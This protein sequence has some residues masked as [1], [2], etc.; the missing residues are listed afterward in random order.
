MCDTPFLCETLAPQDQGAILTIALEDIHADRKGRSHLFLSSICI[1]NT[2][3]RE[4]FI[5]KNIS[6]VAYDDKN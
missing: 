1:H 3:D 2:V 6:S 5:V 4:I